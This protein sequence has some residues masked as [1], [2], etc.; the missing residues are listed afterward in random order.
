MLPKNG[1]IS[2]ENIKRFLL[3]KLINS[4]NACYKAEKFA[5]LEYRTRSLLLDN[6]VEDLRAKTKKFLGTQTSPEPETPNGSNR[7]IDSVKKVFVSRLRSQTSIDRSNNTKAI[8]NNNS[9]YTPELKTQEDKNR[10]REY[11]ISSSKI[12]SDQLSDH[13]SLSSVDLENFV[14]SNLS[15]IDLGFESLTEIPKINDKDET[16]N[17]TKQLQHEISILKEEKLNLLRQNVV[18]I[19]QL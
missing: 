3:T 11:T 13:S 2:K 18:G 16:E 6:L 7:F 14:P 10:K 4:E 15:E 8:K 9:S 19:Y 1:I 5:N 12:Q 17:S